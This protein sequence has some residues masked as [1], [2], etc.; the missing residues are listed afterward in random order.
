[1]KR[2][3]LFLLLFIGLVLICVTI[4]FVTKKSESFNLGLKENITKLPLYEVIDTSENNS[5]V[6]ISFKY[7]SNKFSKNAKTTISDEIEKTDINNIIIL[8][9]DTVQKNK[10]GRIVKKISLDHGLPLIV[11]R[12]NNTNHTYFIN[13]LKISTNF[14]PHGMNC[15]PF[16]DGASADNIFGDGTQN[17]KNISLHYP[18]KNNSMFSAWH[19]HPMFKSSQLLYGNLVMPWIVTDWAS[20]LLEP[21][22]KLNKNDIPIVFGAIDT[23]KEGILNSTRLYNYPCVNLD[24]DKTILQKYPGIYTTPVDGDTTKI[25]YCTGLGAWRGTFLQ[26]NGQITGAY[27]ENKYCKDDKVD[28]CSNSLFCNTDS[29]LNKYIQ[30]LTHEIKSNLLRLRLVHS[31]PSFRRNYF[32]FTDD[33]GNFLDFWVIGLDNGFC[34]PFNTKMISLSSMNR[35]DVVID[36]KKSSQI[37]LVAFDFDITL[38]EKV[39]PFLPYVENPETEFDRDFFDKFSI[40]TGCKVDPNDKN[41]LKNNIF[42]GGNNKKTFLHIMNKLRPKGMKTDK[43]PYFN[44]VKFNVK[45][46][47]NNDLDKVL[48]IISKKIMIRPKLYYFNN[49]TNIER[50]R[51]IVMRS[52]QFAVDCWDGKD[53]IPSLKFKF[54]DSSKYSNLEMTQ[55]TKMTIQKLDKQNNVLQTYDI[56]YKPTKDPINIVKLSYIINQSFKE[57]GIPLE[58]TWA[59]KLQ[60]LN[61]N[62]KIKTVLIKLE[63]LSVHHTYKIVGYDNILQFM[64]VEYKWGS[65]DIDLKDPKKPDMSIFLAATE[66]NDLVSITQHEHDR[67]MG[68]VSLTIPPKS[69]HVG[70]PFQVMNDN[71][72]NFSIKQ[73]KSERWIFHN[74]DQDFFDVHPLHFHLTSGMID[75]EYSSFINRDPIYTGSQDVISIKSG[76]HIA[77][78]IKFNNFNSTMG[79]IKN[80]GYMFHCHYMMHHDMNMMGQF[81]IEPK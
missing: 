55:N 7:G 58:Y 70:N 37:N 9:S 26:V 68:T 51:Q 69:Y 14:H 81:Y 48:E 71:I 19:P 52:G 6:E 28:S 40:I 33:S 8:G 59:K 1:M 62:L 65:S 31:G 11:Y 60:N 75:P 67:A 15:D 73:E 43:I 45:R 42:S 17:G 79:E 4:Y 44:V 76:T 57:N 64:G 21:Y 53:D 22:F 18:I 49:P 13:N 29:C 34:E 12:K 38:V 72:F 36:S 80:L 74:D 3:I 10:N 30:V 20:D 61:N 27:T 54:A 2:N 23:D 16:V 35:A 25:N 50:T 46:K 77:F 78:K 66:N 56:N 63:N 32:G 5:H 24:V 41:S 47:N 39:I